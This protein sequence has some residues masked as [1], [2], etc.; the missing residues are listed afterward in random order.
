MRKSLLKEVFSI[1]TRGKSRFSIALYCPDSHIAYNGHSPDEKGVGGGI[2]A[3]VRALKA[4]A[5]LG[6]QVTA[7]VN[8]DREG[9]Y[10]GVVYRHF[11][12]VK[13][14]RADILIAVTSGGELSLEPLQ[15]VRLQTRLRI[16][17]IHGVPE[18]RGLDLFNPHILYVPSN[19]IQMIVGRRWNTRPRQIFVTPNAIE[20][21]LFCPT[22]AEAMER[23][24]FSL[25]YIGY[26]GK[27]LHHALAVL[28]KLR[29]R[30]PRYHLAVYGDYTL[31]GQDKTLADI[32]QAGVELHGTIPQKRLARQLF[33]HSFLLAL[34]TIEEAFG[35]SL[36]EAKRAGVIPIAS[37]VGGFTE[38]VRHGVDGLLIEGEPSE[39]AT[40]ERAAQAIWELTQ[41]PEQRLTLSKMAMPVPWTWERTARVWVEHWQR[42]LNQTENEPPTSLRRCPIC[43]TLTHRYSDGWRC[44]HCGHFIPEWPTPWQSE[45]R[46]AQCA[47]AS[48]PKPNEDGQNQS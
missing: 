42:L 9:V 32:Q 35:I 10:D 41:H 44:P 38:T 16:G 3:R 24:P 17:W 21:A 18:P 4:L 12:R 33:R 47:K 48:R 25:V 46:L 28:H 27:G 13:Q 1:R 19:F 20:E 34:Q 39:E 15:K 5:R 14:I 2:T 26:P 29:E 37:P 22:P 43:G 40:R 30:E 23:D 31:W 45:A 7:Y 36:I 11:T 8:C 6:H